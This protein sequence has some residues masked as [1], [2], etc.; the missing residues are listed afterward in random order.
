MKAEDVTR[1]CELLEH[2]KTVYDKILI[3]ATAQMNCMQEGNQDKLFATLRALKSLIEERETYNDELISLQEVFSEN[4]NSIF[5]AL[6]QR[7]IK[8]QDA[9]QAVLENIVNQENEAK[10]QAQKQQDDGTKKAAHLAKGKQMNKA[11]GNQNRQR[12]GP[13]HS[14]GMMDTQK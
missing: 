13:S 8:A 7:V 2:D 11:Y 4:K 10:A 3:H 6:A 14:E 12:R 5:P 1:L 9:V